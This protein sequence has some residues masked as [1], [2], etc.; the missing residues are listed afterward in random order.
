VLVRDNLF[1]EGGFPQGCCG[2]VDL[3]L[4]VEGETLEGC[5]WAAG[6]ADVGE[7]GDAEDDGGA[8]VE[9]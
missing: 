3:L 2:E 9:I 7:A 5:L 6:V 4:A 1:L 8:A